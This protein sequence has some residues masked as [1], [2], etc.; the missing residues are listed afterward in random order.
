MGSYF[1]R[2]KKKGKGNMK[3]VLE[4]GKFIETMKFYL[5]FRIQKE[6]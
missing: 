5:C 2:L 3:F 1:E 6:V 4:E